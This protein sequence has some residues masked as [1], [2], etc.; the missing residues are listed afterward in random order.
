MKRILRGLIWLQLVI[1]IAQAHGGSG[2]MK[3]EQIIEKLDLKPLPGEGGYYR[4]TYRSE[5][6]DAPATIFG[7]NSTDPRVISTAIY[8]L[9]TADSFSAL[10]RIE[11]DEVF[12]FYSGDPVE[13]IQID[14]TG[15]LT[16]YILGPDILNGETPQVVV[17]KGT[18]QGL[19][20]KDDGSW[21]LM[22][23]TVSPGFEFQDFELGDRDKL[24][25]KFPHYREDIENYT[26]EGQ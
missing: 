7:I 5:R 15:K 6:V 23:T 9:V 2:N 8:Y 1:P 13:M 22:G 10:H 11:S 19:K 3:A 21:A 26:R 20:L 24:I 12:H 18:W 17:R 14:L 16:R 4:E 25:K